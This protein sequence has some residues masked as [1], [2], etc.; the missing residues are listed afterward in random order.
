MKRGY[1]IL[2]VE[3]ECKDC[4][5]KCDSKNAMP[6]AKQHAKKYKH[7]VQG[8]EERIWSYNARDEGAST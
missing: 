5:W 3:A 2:G 6:L 4:S 8:Y 1:G 7:Y